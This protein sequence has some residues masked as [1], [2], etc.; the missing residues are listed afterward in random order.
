[1]AGGYAWSLTQSET[2]VA[3]QPLRVEIHIGVGCIP[4]TNLCGFTTDHWTLPPFFLPFLASSPPALQ[5]HMEKRMN[6]PVGRDRL[7]MNTT[8]LDVYPCDV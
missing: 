7:G 4:A 1:M 3:W 2:G 6:E 8:K 5:G